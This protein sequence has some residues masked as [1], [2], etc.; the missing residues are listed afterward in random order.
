MMPYIYNKV[1]LTACRLLLLLLTMALTCCGASVPEDAKSVARKAHVLPDNDGATLPPN[2]APLNVEVLEPGDAYV[3]RYYTKDGT[4]IV[5]GSNPSDISLADWREL[6]SVARGDT[7]YTDIYVKNDGHWSRFQTL[8]NPVATDSIDAYVTYRLIQPSYVDYED[9]TIRQRDISNF[10]ERIVFHNMMLSEDEKGQCI[11][12]HVPQNQNRTGHSLF[13]VRQLK[14]G[15]VLIDNHTA[16]KV[17]LKTDSTLSAGVYPAWHPLNDQLIAFSVNETG[18]VFHTRD[19]QKIEVIDFGSNLILYDAAKNQVYDIDCRADE[20][21]TFPTWSPDGQ[22]LYY[23]SAHYEQQS[24]NI[25]AE[26]NSAYPLLKYNIYRRS[27]DARTKKFG[28]RELVF[29]AAAIGKSASTPRVSPD[30]KWLLF[31]LADFGQFHIWHSSSRLYA[32]PTGIGTEGKEPLTDVHPALDTDWGAASYHSFSS[33]GRWVVFSS[34]RDDGNYTRLY[35]AYFDRNGQMHKPFLL[36]QRSPRYYGQ[37]FRS[38]NVPEFLAQPV[39]PSL[40]DLTRVV[41]QPALQAEYAGSSLQVPEARHGVSRQL[42]DSK[43][44]VVSSVAY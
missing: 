41:D 12:C 23:V 14:G 19:V 8:K 9:M 5:S 34:R 21:E 1:K 36:P 31:A 25:D 2:I 33:N 13:H 40:N 44:S 15:T 27:F 35:I 43:Q 24:D 18:Q 29:D 30:G 42:N 32:M 6:L 4:E 7:L 28:E 37:L 3:V 26:L 39:A 11:N 10:D 38:Y 20:F 22:W 16:T 17:N